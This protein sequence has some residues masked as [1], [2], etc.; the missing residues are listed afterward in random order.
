M[1]MDG[2]ALKFDA[3]IAALA[4]PK[5]SAYSAAAEGIT[6]VGK[7]MLQEDKRK[8]DEK[9]F[10]LQVKQAEQGIEKGGIDMQLAQKQLG[11]YDEDKRLTRRNLTT[12]IESGE[13]D[14]TQ[15][16]K[17]KADSDALDAMKSFVTSSGIDLK[18]PKA[19]EGLRGELLKQEQFKGREYVIN[20][21]I[22]N[23]SDDAIKRKTSQLHLNT[24]EV[25]LDTTKEQNKVQKLFGEKNAQAELEMKKAQTQHYVNQDKIGFMNAKTSRINAESGGSGGSGKVD[26]SMMLDYFAK[27]QKSF[28]RNPTDGEMS[29][30]AK[31]G[32]PQYKTTNDLTDGQRKKLEAQKTA[33]REL[34]K[35]IEIGAGYIKPVGGM[36]VLPESLVQKFNSSKLGKYSD[37]ERKMS[38]LLGSINSEEKHRLYGAALTG[39]EQES[40]KSWNLDTDQP[41][42]RLAMNIRTLRNRIYEQYLETSK[43][44]YNE[45]YAPNNEFDAKFERQ[46]NGNKKAGIAGSAPKFDSTVKNNTPA[47][48]PKYSS[49]QMATDKKTGKQMRYDGRGWVYIN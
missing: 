38:A 18:D 6:N 27:F 11:D 12:Q 17:V 22:N 21:L 25:N 13:I 35:V 7:V 23:L 39:N 5:D 34:D 43:G 49:G 40:A 37:K 31:T 26:Q 33:L 48:A 20:D 16:K 45:G 47:A 14:L 32:K 28:G 9:L 29:E 10:D 8:K 19:I 30:F 1:R 46:Y 41:P 15:K 3:Q 4:M 36:N 2:S 44:V 42:E 24:A